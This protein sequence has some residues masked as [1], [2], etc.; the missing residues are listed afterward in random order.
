METRSI[1]ETRNVVEVSRFHTTPSIARPSD[2]VAY[3]VT[4]STVASKDHTFD[5]PLV[6]EETSHPFVRE[7]NRG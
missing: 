6:D 5:R 7:L 4:L 1:P 2:P 3:I